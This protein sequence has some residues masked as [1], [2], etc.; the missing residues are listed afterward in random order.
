MI[1][2]VLSR[3]AETL[4]LAVISCQEEKPNEKRSLL[5]IQV[6]EKLFPIGI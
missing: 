5:T 4:T 1:L 6:G 3:Y 2:K